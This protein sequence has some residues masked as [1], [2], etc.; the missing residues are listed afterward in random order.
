L[1]SKTGLVV[2]EQYIKGPLV[3]VHMG[4][5]NQ[6]HLLPNTKTCQTSSLLEFVII[7]LLFSSEYELA[8]LPCS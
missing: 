2:N 1:D 6:I 3:V 4:E 5:E 7:W 8:V